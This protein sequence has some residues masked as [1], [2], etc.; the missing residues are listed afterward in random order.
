MVLLAKL[1]SKYWIGTK[2]FPRA[3]QWPYKPHT[4]HPCFCWGAIRGGRYSAGV[5]GHSQSWSAQDSIGK[6]SLTIRSA[7]R[8]DP[9]LDADGNQ[10]V[11]LYCQYYAY[12]KIDKPT[13][14][15]RAITNQNTR[16]VENEGASI[17]TAWS[18]YCGLGDWRILLHHV[19]MWVFHSIEQRHQD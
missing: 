18:C 10:S 15:Q 16:P 4:H 9:R 19:I 14:K 8:P 13:K 3:D 2:L 7:G 1:L 11:L 17:H 6:I 5:V 12:A